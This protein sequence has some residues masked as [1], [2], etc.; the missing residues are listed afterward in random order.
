MDGA[1]T[2]VNQLTLIWISNANEAASVRTYLSAFPY[3]QDLDSTGQPAGGKTVIW[4]DRVKTRADVLT[5]VLKAI[6]A[7]KKDLNNE[8][9]ECDLKSRY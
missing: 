9:N 6:I 2:K 8:V 3:Y 5:I 7:D 1:P 4:D